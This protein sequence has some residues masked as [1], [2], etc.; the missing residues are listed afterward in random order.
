V[1]LAFLNDFG[2]LETF[3]VLLH[4]PVEL[5]C[6]FEEFLNHL[7]NQSQGI[8]KSN[9]D[10][11]EA[12]HSLV[13]VAL[14]VL[15]SVPHLILLSRIELLLQMVIQNIVHDISLELFVRDVDVL[16]KLLPLAIFVV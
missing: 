12:S 9:V 14:F 11:V 4:F 5:L 15:N 13:V 8:I 16:Q 2:A 3:T 1:L 10:H 7:L 6:F